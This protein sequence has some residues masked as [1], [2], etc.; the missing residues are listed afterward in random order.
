MKNKIGFFTLCYDETQ[1][2][3]FAYNSLKS[4]YPEAPIFLNSESKEDFIFLKKYIKN[5]HIEN[6]E[7]TQ[8]GLFKYKPGDHVLEENRIKNKK[9]VLILL[10][11]LEKAINLLQ[12]DY[13]LMHCPDTLVRGK[14][15][16]PNDSGLL[17][18][19]VNNYFFPEINQILLK[20]RGIEI[21]A[22]GAVPAIFK[23]EDFLKAKYIFLQNK[24]ILEELCNNFYAVFSH[25]IILPILFALIGK[26][27]E[28]NPEITECTRNFNWITSSHPL[29]HQFRFFYPHRTSKYKS[30][31][32]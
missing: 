22:F 14:I 13:I 4:Y 10:E 20:N 12:T 3:H 23:S 26:Q 6:V 30:D 7:D 9:A 25:D 2:L 5:I 18:S 27:E 28:Y 15:T 32:K 16:I 21:T 8:S 29:I 11:R 24:N 17:G 31:E 1:A 19:R